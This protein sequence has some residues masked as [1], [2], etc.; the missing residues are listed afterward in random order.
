MHG[1]IGLHAA[2]IGIQ[3]EVLSRACEKPIPPHQ[4][5][6]IPKQAAGT[7]AGPSTIR[8]AYVCRVS[9]CA[10][11]FS[12]SASIALLP[13]SV[14]Q[15]PPAKHSMLCRSLPWSQSGQLQSREAALFC[16]AIGCAAA[17][18]ASCSAPAQAEISAP[19][20]HLHYSFIVATP[21]APKAL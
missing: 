8:V 13:F 10:R 16:G 4:S 9:G 7:M 11:Q 18:L 17:L 15:T 21:E 5:Q 1:Q 6:R 3:A 2:E 20:D 19:Q 12:M 14:L